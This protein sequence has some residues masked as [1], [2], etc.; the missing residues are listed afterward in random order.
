MVSNRLLV[1]EVR[2]VEEAPWI[3]CKGQVVMHIR[4]K[5]SLLF[6]QRRIIRLKNMA[7]LTVN[8]ISGQ[9]CVNTLLFGL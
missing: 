1:L 2:P 7:Y 4:L 6:I 5:L 9:I 8:K 3:L